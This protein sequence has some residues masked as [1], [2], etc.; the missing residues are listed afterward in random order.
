MLDYPQVS[1][2]V[3]QNCMT[4]ISQGGA[5][6]AFEALGISDD[7][8]ALVTGSEPWIGA[9]RGRVTSVLDGLTHGVLD[10]L[11]LPR[12]EVP[13]EFRA[14][15]LATFVTAGNLAVACRWCETEASAQEI[16]LGGTIAPVSARQLFALCLQLQPYGPTNRGRWLKK[17]GR[18]IRDAEPL[19][20]VM[21]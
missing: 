1:L 21:P 20:E 19:K 15:I 7:D 18:A 2:A 10:V 14:S 5:S 13:C 3:A 12:I 9:D 16:S 17:T 8:F 4:V 11:G 6:D